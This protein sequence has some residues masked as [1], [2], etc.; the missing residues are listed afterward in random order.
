MSENRQN[1]AGLPSENEIGTTLAFLERG[2]EDLQRQLNGNL[3]SRSHLLIALSSVVETNLRPSN[4]SS[5]DVLCIS[6]TESVLLL[7]TA[8]SSSTRPA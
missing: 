7:R 3:T 6:A 5:N 8:M 1:P 2:F 4:Q